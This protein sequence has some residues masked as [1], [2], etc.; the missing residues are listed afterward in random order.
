MK[1]KAINVFELILAV[2]FITAHILW[3]SARIPFMGL[4]TVLS[5]GILAMLYFYGGFIV[6]RSPGIAVAN[7]IVYGA[8]FSCAVIGLLFTFQ[9]WPHAPLFI[10][11]D[12]V[13]FALLALVRLLAV[14]L[15]KQPTVLQ[16]SPGVV[17][18]YFTL[19][20]LLLYAFLSKP[21]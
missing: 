7:L 3:V 13:I 11:I 21:N 8:A 6:L 12:L 17:L 2:L 5:G 14:Y 1:L 4:I 20:I 10:I 15:F 18:R 16:R 19:F 9:K